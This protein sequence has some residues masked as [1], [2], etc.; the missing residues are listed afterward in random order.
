MRVARNRKIRE[1]PGR[2][3]LTPTYPVCPRSGT[4]AGGSAAAKAKLDPAGPGRARSG[5]AGW[6]IRSSAYTR[7]PRARGDLPNGVQVAAKAKL[8][9]AGPARAGPLGIPAQTSSHQAMSRGPRARCPHGTR[10]A[11]RIRCA[12]AG[13]VQ[14]AGK[15]RGPGP[16]MGS[17]THSQSPNPEEH[18]TAPRL[19]AGSRSSPWPRQ[20]SDNLNLTACEPERTNGL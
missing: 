15:P 6:N 9:P 4:Q 14:G 12:P 10:A 1:D 5:P 20:D 8:D 7:T 13:R 18:R 19:A 17:H 2:Q 11:N 16:G 3:A